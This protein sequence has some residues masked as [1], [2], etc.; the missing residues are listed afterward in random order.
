MPLNLVHAVR[1]VAFGWYGYHL[2]AFEMVCG[3]FGSLDQG[4]CRGWRRHR[5]LEERPA[6]ER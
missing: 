3:E 6:A 5:R 2:H 4:I 1:Q